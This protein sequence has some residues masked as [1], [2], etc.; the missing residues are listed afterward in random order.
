LISRGIAP[1]R[2]LGDLLKEAETLSIEN[3]CH[4]KEKILTLLKEKGFW[5]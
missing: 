1:G 3:E 2:L 4:D 5:K